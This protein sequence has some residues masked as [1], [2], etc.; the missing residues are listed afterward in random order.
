MMDPIGLQQISTAVD[1]LETWIEGEEFA[2]WD[3]FD[4]LNSP[5]LSRL[6]FTNR[7]I[8][9]IWVQLLK[10]SPVN[11][12]P[13]LRVPKGRNP[14]AAGLFLASYWRKYLMT[15]N[16]DHLKRAQWFAQWLR[17]NVSPG[18]LGSCWGYNFDWP[19]RVFFAPQGTPTIVGTATIGLAFMDILKLP[20]RSADP[21]FEKNALKTARSACE[22][23]LRNLHLTRPSADELCFSYTPLDRTF[24][25]NA[26]LLGG[27]LLAEVAAAT[28]E[29]DLAAAAQASARYSANRQRRDGSWAYGEGSQY[30]W[31][32]GFHTGYVLVALKRIGA[33]LGTTEFEQA[34]ERGYEYWRN[35]FF[36]QKGVPRYY[37]ESTY[38]IDAHGVAQ[39]ILTF[40]EFTDQD[41]EAGDRAARTALW[42]TDHM[43]GSAGYFHY[44]IHRTYR[45][46]IPY[47]RW[48]Q[49]WMHRALVELQR[50]TVN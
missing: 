40:L 11:L 45:I 4:A 24:I 39:A 41:P 15:Q 47:M 13:L 9:Q 35:V 49:A 18:Y 14:K 46:R 29:A 3:P 43:Q 42:A 21:E 5:I 48:S 20:A 32:D 34:V 37:S 22:F 2:G 23:L 7:R 17:E 25:H 1:R 28:S 8:G 19:N 33:A 16:E 50:R 36:T 6:T 26:N 27:S 38:P 10:R 30:T 31:V 44:Q 12:R